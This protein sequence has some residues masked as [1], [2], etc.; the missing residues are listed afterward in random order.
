MTV[1]FKMLHK[2][3]GDHCQ[4][5][6]SDQISARRPCHFCRTAAETGKYRKSD[7]TDQEVYD[8][9]DGAEFVPSTKTEKY[10]T[11]FVNEIGTGLNGSGILNGP[12]MQVSAV[13]NAINVICFVVRNFA[14]VSMC[15]VLLLYTLVPVYE[16]DALLSTFLLL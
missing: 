2:K 4:K 5:H 9:T 1:S 3:S 10:N 8:I 12:R 11:R 13:I 6:K 16:R 7:Q 14:F 15:F